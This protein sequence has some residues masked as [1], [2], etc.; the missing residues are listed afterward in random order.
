MNSRRDLAEATAGPASFEPESSLAGPLLTTGEAA[1]LLG[2]SE[3]T[4]KLNRLAGRGIPFVKLGR[5]IRYSR[6]DIERHAPKHDTPDREGLPVT[7]A[8][9]KPR[10]RKAAQPPTESWVYS[11]RVL[12]GEI[13]PKDRA[14]TARLANGRRL[15]SFA[16]ER[17]AMR[18]IT[19]AARDGRAPSPT[20]IQG[21]E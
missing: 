9:R 2:L 13:K 8:D 20:E 3:Q 1:D 21:S 14:F 6:S 15:G 19:T 7:A 17:A 4:L 16:D 18:A 10:R 11:G 12:I 5:A